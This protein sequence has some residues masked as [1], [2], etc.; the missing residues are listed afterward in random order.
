MWRVV[1]SVFGGFHEIRPLFI[2]I[3]DD[4]ITAGWNSVQKLDWRYPVVW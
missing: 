2:S 1:V 3:H 4:G